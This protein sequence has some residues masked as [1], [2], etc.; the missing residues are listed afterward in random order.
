MA[1]PNKTKGDRAERAVVDYL[2][3]FWPTI[4][5]RAGFTD[6]LGDVIATT[7][8]GLLVVQVKDC[9]SARWSEWFDQ[10]DEQG[11]TCTARA[12]E[13]VLGGILVWKRRGS[14]DPADWRVLS[15]L[16]NFA[17]MLDTLTEPE[18]P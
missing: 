4:R 17:H 3:A 9:S 2:S 12:H 7:D 11:A 6:D 15:R 10:L 14:G 16:D 8:A 13:P 1:H 5:T 18:E